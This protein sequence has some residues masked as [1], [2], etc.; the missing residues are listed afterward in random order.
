MIYLNDNN[1]R[2]AFC[3]IRQ[4][5]MVHFVITLTNKHSPIARK[6]FDQVIRVVKALHCYMS[7]VGP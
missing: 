4:S 6:H 3:I 2:L 1:E 7:F 5:H